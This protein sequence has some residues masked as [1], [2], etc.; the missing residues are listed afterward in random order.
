MDYTWIIE[1]NAFCA[2]IMGIILYSVF[3]NYD[4]QTKQRYYM[5]SILAGMISFA[6]EINWS[7]I[8]GGFLKEPPICNFITNAIYDIVSVMMGYYWLC[9]VEAALG[10][11]F[12]KSKV[13]KRIA[14]I[15]VAIVI[16][17]V[18]ASYFTGWIFYV[19]ENNV[20]HR[21][22]FVVLHVI[23]C[24]IYTIITSVHAL[25][26]SIRSEV[27]LKTV[28]YRILSMFLVF[29]LA[30]GIIQIIFPAI[31]SVSI[32]ITLSFLYVYID[33]QNLLI[34]VDTLSGLN[35]RNQ[36]LR[37]LGSRMRNDSEKGKLYIFMLDVNKFKKINDTYGHVEGDKALIRCATALKRAN[38][39]TRNFIGRY[40]GDEFIIIA[41]LDG[42]EAA[43]KLCEKTRL[44]LEGICRDDG[45]SYDLSF[46]FG[47]TIYSDEYKTMHAFIAAADKKL[48]EAKK[49]RTE[50]NQPAN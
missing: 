44:E 14:L 8:E 40:G 4:R 16:V 35:N 3:R 5:K 31:P 18:I 48:Y 37:Y 19:D 22:D 11:K 50:T 27:Y 26:K 41:D 28:E 38:R 6:C 42:D 9:Y 17:A 39:D 43:E 30:I 46:S 13:L 49:R 23:L 45:V 29:P 20:Y 32:G 25:I 24:H 12:L 33:L 21:G 34:S 7:L 47:Y 2:A 1:I 36:L 15:P 10:S